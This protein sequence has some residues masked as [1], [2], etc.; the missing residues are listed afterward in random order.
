M[1]PVLYGCLLLM[2]SALC[3]SYQMQKAGYVTQI[4]DEDGNM[5]EKSISVIVLR[6]TLIIFVPYSLVGTLFLTFNP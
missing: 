5:E 1:N 3:L 4:T 2:Y 6:C